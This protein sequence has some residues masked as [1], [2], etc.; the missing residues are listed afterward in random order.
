V[1][2]TSDHGEMMGGHGRMQKVVYYDES[3]RIPFIIRWPEKLDPGENKLH[4]SVPDIMPTLLSLMGLNEKIPE[5]VEGEDFSTAFLGREQ[6][7]PEFALYLNPLFDS[8]LGGMRG[9]RN[10]HY[11]FVIERNNEGEVTKS[12]LFDNVNY[13]FQLK[14]IADENPQLVKKFDKQIFK[15]LEEIN[16][17]WIKYALK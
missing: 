6:E 11:T 16:D 8:A 2:F 12:I 17:P 4:L 14:N 10:D 13:P 5:D 1:V 7:T 9:L 15:K 3:L